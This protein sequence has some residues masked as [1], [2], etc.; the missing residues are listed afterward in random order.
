MKANDVD[1]SVTL[2]RTCSSVDVEIAIIEPLLC[3]SISID[4]SSN[5]SSSSSRSSSSISSS[6]CCCCCNAS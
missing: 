5:R 1:S 6:S 3:S 4:S 2:L